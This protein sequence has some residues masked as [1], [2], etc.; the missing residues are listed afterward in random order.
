MKDYLYVPVAAKPRN[1]VGRVCANRPLAMRLFG[2]YRDSVTLTIMKLF[3]FWE[4]ESLK[5]IYI[6]CYNSNV[7][8]DK[9]IFLRGSYKEIFLSSFRYMS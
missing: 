5:K 8:M 7:F 9:S 4:V 6:P 3:L 1:W 2:C